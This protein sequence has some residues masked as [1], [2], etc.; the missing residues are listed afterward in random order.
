MTVSNFLLV[1]FFTRE[2]ENMHQNN[3]KIFEN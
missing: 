3:L 1:K 2:P